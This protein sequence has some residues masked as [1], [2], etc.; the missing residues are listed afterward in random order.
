MLVSLDLTWELPETL[1]AQLTAQNVALDE[2]NDDE[3]FS[4]EMYGRSN[5]LPAVTHDIRQ[6]YIRLH[7][8]MAETWGCNC[9]AR[10]VIHLRL[11]S[12]DSP[13]PGPNFEV[14]FFFYGGSGLHRWQEGRVY[15]NEVSA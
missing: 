12:C 1:L 9:R 13:A 2:A 6:Y 10:H 8:A 7:K 14:D 3:D 11:N 5:Q 4:P 15:V